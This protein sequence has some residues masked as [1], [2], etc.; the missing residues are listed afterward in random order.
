MITFNSLKD[1]AKK[2]YSVKDGI[3][4][5]KELKVYIDEYN[6]YFIWTYPEIADYI[7]SSYRY[8]EM[9]DNEED[10]IKYIIDKYNISPLELF[11]LNR[12]AMVDTYIKCKLNK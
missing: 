11:N 1:L 10:F 7:Y 9:F 5:I 4:G 8:L 6:D 12:D 2:A 3:E